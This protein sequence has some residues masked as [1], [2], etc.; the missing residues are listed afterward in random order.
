MLHLH[1]QLPTQ[2]MQ[3]L[4]WREGEGGVSMYIEQA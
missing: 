2:V 3:Q 4:L 1:P